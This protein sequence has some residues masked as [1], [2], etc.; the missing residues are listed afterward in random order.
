MCR[1]QRFLQN[2]ELAGGLQRIPR[3]DSGQHRPR[4]VC[5]TANPLAQYNGKA[6]G[7]KIEETR[8]GLSKRVHAL[9]GSFETMV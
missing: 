2:S 4:R 7:A 6:M 5:A 9:V 3:R 1:C 8:R